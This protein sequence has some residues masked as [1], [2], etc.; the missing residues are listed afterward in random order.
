MRRLLAAFVGTALLC[1]AAPADERD[2]ALEELLRAINSVDAYEVPKLDMRRDHNYAA[3]AADVAPFGPVKPF[4]EHFLEQMEYTG[5]GRA[6]PEPAHLETVKL[7]FI[8]PIMPTV[9]V[10]TGGRS[11]EE[12]LGIQMLQG[13]RLAIEQANAQGGYHARGIPFELV[14]KNDNGLW[15]ASGNE[16]VDL[17]YRDRVWAILGTIDGANSH[18]AIRVALKAEIL[19]INTGDTDPT[20]IETNIP[21]VLRNIGDDRQ[22]GYLLVDYLYRKQQ[23][24]RVGIIR[25]SNRYGRFGVREIRDGSRRLGHP[26]VLEMAYEVGADDFSL[27]LERLH[28][29]DVQAIVHWGDAED[30]ARIL[31]QM[32]AMGMDQPF[33][34]CDR[35]VSD[36]FVEIAGANAEGVIATYPW[37]PRRADERLDAFRMDFRGRFGVEPG[38]YAAHGYDGM[39]MLIWAVQA[40]GLNRAKIRDV[41]AHWPGPHRGVTGDIVLSAALD[42]VGEVFLA[43]FTEGQ[44]EFHSREDLQIPRAGVAADRPHKVATD[45]PPHYAGPGREDPDPKGLREILIGYF[46]PGDPQDPR[47]GDL[48]LAAS[49][50]IEQANEAGG[51]HGLPYRL[52][53]VWASDPWGTGVARIARLVYARHVWAI[54]GSVDGAATHLAEQVV[55][56][57]RL[58][59]VSPA[60]TDHTVALAGVPW[61]FSCLP[62]DD[63]NAALLADALAAA[64][65]GEPI[66]VLS[67][68][69]HDSRVAAGAL[70]DAL[71][72][73]GLPVERYREL[74]PATDFPA[75]VEGL[76]GSASHIVILAGPGES[77]ALLRY[78]RRNGIGTRYFAG[79][80]AGRG[81]FQ[82][83]AAD[84]AEGVVFPYP[85]DG[86]PSDGFAEAFH[87]RCGRWPDCFA[88]QAYDAA[89]LLVAAI[90]QAGLNRV[91]IRDALDGL[92]P[93]PGEAGMIRWD[94]LGRNERAPRLATIRDGRIVMLSADR[95]RRAR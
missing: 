44:W 6:I 23:Y 94:V 81:T 13:A 20:F 56:K 42:D 4:K 45:H 50:A 69:D 29:S 87:E 9:S 36:E 8:G 84:A 95:P 18:I 66:T 86:E 40:V 61:M 16:I 37:N 5:P 46:G 25:A 83:K 10:A 63:R 17:A 38:T 49:L 62:G 30:G 60:S 34:G 7:G 57:A 58:P 26:I 74:G 51:Y 47:A 54:L 28:R 55:A 70:L 27:V 76:Q 78:L 32:R 72:R 53:P 79:P 2:E 92:S 91:R 67:A 19:M 24:E 35:T 82:A 31:N 1:A 43:R 90:E 73:R 65:P 89:R 3:T 93:W 15:G 77:A 52:V 39:N 71:G 14:V 33:F 80:A 85:C 64:G 22:M 68:T 88:R 41:L 75:L 12:G 59:L 48:W 11:H 21:W